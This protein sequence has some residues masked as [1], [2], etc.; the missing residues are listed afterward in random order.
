[1]KDITTTQL[2]RYKSYNYYHSEWVKRHNVKHENIDFDK[3]YVQIT[4]IAN[5]SKVN[6]KDPHTWLKVIYKRF[7]HCNCP[8]LK[9]DGTNHSLD[10]CRHFQRSQYKKLQ[11]GKIL[12][13]CEKNYKVKYYK[14]KKLYKP[15]DYEIYFYVKSPCLNGVKRRKDK[16]K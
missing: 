3:S 10:M 14:L 4:R 15:I 16:R 8:N 7:F 2:K 11:A 1:M 5:Y 13:R 6:P 12:K 9:G